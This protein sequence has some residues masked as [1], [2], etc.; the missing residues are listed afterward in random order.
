MQFQISG[1]TPE[2]HRAFWELVVPDDI[3]GGDSNGRAY[4]TGFEY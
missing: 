3:M 2:F 1:D 4:D